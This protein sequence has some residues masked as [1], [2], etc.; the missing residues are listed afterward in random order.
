MLKKRANS[1]PKT[2]VKNPFK[3]VN[4]ANLKPTDYNPKSRTEARA[5]R[6]LKHSIMTRG[7]ISPIIARATRNTNTFEV[8]EGHRRLEAVKSI[9]QDLKSKVKIPALWAR[10]YPQDCE[11]DKIFI[12]ANANQMKVNGKQYLEQIMQGGINAIPEREQKKFLHLKTISGIKS[13]LA[14]AEK[15]YNKRSSIGTVYTI[16]TAMNNYLD[17]GE[18]KKI[19]NYIL[20]HDKLTILR[21]KFSEW[22]ENKNNATKLWNKIRRNELI[23]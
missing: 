20:K 5:I 11:K 3:L 18:Q 7:Q 23:A 4:I 16:L 10:V 13:N 22:S 12:D 1:K 14:L 6:S 9:N 15:I 8:I 2:H 19:F 17:R 21:G